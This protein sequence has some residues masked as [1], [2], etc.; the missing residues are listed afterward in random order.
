ML[1]V[2][3]ELLRASTNYWLWLEFSLDFSLD[4]KAFATLTARNLNETDGEFCCKPTNEYLKSKLLLSWSFLLPLKRVSYLRGRQNSETLDIF[5]TVRTKEL[6]LFCKLHFCLN[7]LLFEQ[8][9]KMPKQK[10]SFFV[11]T[12][13]TENV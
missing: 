4:N 7:I 12:V 5:R 6:P 11:L 9:E 13:D 1:K 3:T 10:E 8:N 2:G